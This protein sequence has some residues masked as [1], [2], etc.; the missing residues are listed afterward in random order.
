MI[1][2]IDTESAAGFIAG[3]ITIVGGTYG[4]LKGKGYWDI[5]KTKLTAVSFEEAQAIKK[6]NG[7]ALNKLELPD[8][9]I[10]LLQKYS[11]DAEGKVDADK[12]INILKDYRKIMILIT[13]NKS[14]TDP[15]K[16]ECSDILLKI[17]ANYKK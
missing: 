11:S 5:W 9:F 12:F 1:I 7:N 10:D 3:L 16:K 14:L 15:E 6:Q 2:T 8:E 13:L 4:Y 17:I